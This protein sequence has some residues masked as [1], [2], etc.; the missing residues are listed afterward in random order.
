MMQVLIAIEQQHRPGAEDWLQEHVC[1]AGVQ[2]MVGPLEELLGELRIEH[3]HETFVEDRAELYG[4]AIA[5]AARLQEAN[6]S[7]Y[8]PRGLKAPG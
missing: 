4:T 2:L 6:S 8:E 7:E 1:L 5:S 3:H